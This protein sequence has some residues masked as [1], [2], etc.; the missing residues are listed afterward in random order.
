MPNGW[1][2]NAVC[3]GLKL[4]LGFVN[5]L[6]K[7]QKQVAKTLHNRATTPSFKFLSDINTHPPLG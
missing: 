7:L 6:T 2:E 5:E 4:S 1:W 3:A